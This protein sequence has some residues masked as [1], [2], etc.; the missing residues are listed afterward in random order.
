MIL[1]VEDDPLLSS[2]LA[3]KLV[4][5]LLRVVHVQSGEEALEVLKRDEKPDLILLDIRLPGIDG[6]T[7]LEKMRADASMTKIPVIVLSNFGE[8]SDLERSKQLGVLKH[9]VKISLTP[10]EIT[11]VVRDALG[12][13]PGAA[14]AK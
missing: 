10:E 2:L 3:Q 4:A 12:Q 7:V 6:F 5:D 1:M 11:G 14:P 8:A 13:K 9:I